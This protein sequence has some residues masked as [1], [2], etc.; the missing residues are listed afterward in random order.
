ML[1]DT[2]VLNYVFRNM[3]VLKFYICDIFIYD[4]RIADLTSNKAYCAT[5]IYTL[6]HYSLQTKTP[7]RERSRNP[8]LD[9]GHATR[10][11]V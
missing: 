4:V 9:S 7:T 2:Q 11:G 3:V 6:D 8:H 1:I 5:C 10:V